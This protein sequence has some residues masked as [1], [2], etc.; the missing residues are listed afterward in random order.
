M[1]LEESV[2][3]TLVITIV[4][5]FVGTAAICAWAGF[6]LAGLRTADPL[7]RLAK[8]NADKHAELI[9]ASLL[10]EDV[11]QEGAEGLKDLFHSLGLSPRMLT[12]WLRQA[13]L[14]VSTRWVWLAAGV[15]SLLAVV[16]A[17]LLYAPISTLP[18][19]ALVAAGAPIYF[20]MWRRKRRMNAFS[21]QLPDALELMA[22]AIRS[23]NTFQSAMQVLVEETLPPLSKEF[24][25]VSESAKLGIPVEQALDEL[26]ERLPNPDLQF[27]VT[28]VSMQRT[29][30]G[31]LAEILD[32][33][34]WLVRERFY[35]QG[36]VQALTGEGR[37]SGLV[38][39]AL[40]VLLFIIVYALNPTYVMLLFTEPLGQK[41]LAGAI[42]LQILGAVAI[43]RIVN[44]KI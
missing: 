3:S 17:R 42:V 33:I 23:G 4:A 38:L 37:M 18:L 39:Q 30:G 20:V 9:T 16:V 7:G 21:Q 24:E 35:I 34:S 41:M 10:K 44:I 22:S 15:S 32:K 11:L 1:T 40:P 13:E 14:P 43:R 29:T 6:A 19:V 28:A 8:F 25:T 12:D 27:F 36:Q 5:V 2:M 26:A 31:D